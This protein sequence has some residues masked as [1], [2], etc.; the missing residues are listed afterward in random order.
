MVG[1]PC[2]PVQLFYFNTRNLFA[3]IA[4]I[5]YQKRIPERCS[6][7][8]LETLKSWREL[9]IIA[10]ILSSISSVQIFSYSSVR[11]AGIGTIK[12]GQLAAS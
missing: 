9:Q 7:P 11:A 10:V 5:V 12:G 8:F 6:L 2:G 1:A 3:T 4:G